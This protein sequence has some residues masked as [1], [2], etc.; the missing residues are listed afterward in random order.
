LYIDFSFAMI[1]RTMSA[2]L[3]RTLTLRDLTYLV[4]GAVIGSGIFIVP[5]SVYRQ[6]DGS[7]VL[8]L[9]VWLTGG[10]LSLLGALTYGELSA[11]NPQAGGLYIYI[12]DCFGK[13]AAFLFG[14]T[15]FFVIGSGSVATLAVAFSAYLSEIIPLSPMAG[16]VVAILMI[17]CVA[18]VNVRGTRQSADLQNW[19]TVVK[20]IAILLMSI[21]LF[22]LGSRFGESSGSLWP[23]QFNKEVAMGFGAAMIGVLWAYEGWQYATFSAGEAINPQRTFPRAFL[24]GTTILIALYMIANLA[25]IAALGPKAAGATDSIAATSISAVLG[26]SAAKLV[27]IAILISILGATNSVILTTTRVFYAMAADG[28][29]FKA[30][31]VIHPRFHTPA[32]AVITSSIWASALAARGTYQQLLTY[33]IFWGW[34]FYALAAASIF[35]YRKRISTESLPYQVPGY[36]WPPLLFVLAGTALVANTVI[37]QP[38]QAIIGS[39]LVLLGIPAYLYWQ[40]RSNKASL[41]AET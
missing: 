1:P 21:T 29:F 20:V 22:L 31:A 23:A 12:R 4:V 17:A 8:A 15:L 28:L 16:K 10:I 38:K 41:P 2:T 6:V 27:S 32:I 9:L 40:A 35:I 30:L 26:K 33:V 5:G 14:W 36:P 3:N 13:L 24:I 37:A 11:M 19:T 39:A 25:Y 18:A 34:I 7:V